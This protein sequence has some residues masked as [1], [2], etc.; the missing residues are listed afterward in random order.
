MKLNVI[1]ATLM[2]AF[3]VL[4]ASLTYIGL[5]SNK[6]QIDFKGLEK[7]RSESMNTQNQESFDRLLKN[8]G[9]S[10]TVVKPD[11]LS[12]TDTSRLSLAIQLLD[13]NKQYAYAGVLSEKLAGIQHSDYRYFMASRYFLMETYSHENPQNE[14]M[15]IKKSKA[16]LE[17]SLEIK[18][19][20]QDAKVDLA[21]CIHNINK[22]QT[23]DNQ[24][25]LMKPAQLLLQ[26]VR[27]NPNHIDGLYYLGKLAIES[28]QLEKAIERFKKLVSLQPQNQEFYIELSKIYTMQGNTQEAKE[29]A[30]KAQNLK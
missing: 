16:N 9:N 5:N 2:V 10:T 8:I 15:F 13:T 3:L 21:I 22:M 28:N 11:I 30:D 14:L 12:S 1:K 7:K 24:M 29:W 6:A 4:T 26:V 27:E 17:K 25:E 20:N 23:P 18:P 19:D